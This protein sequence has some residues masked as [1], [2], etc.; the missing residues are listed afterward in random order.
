MMFSASGE[1]MTLSVNV[2][3][4][5]STPE[6]PN[7]SMAVVEV[8]GSATAPLPLLPFIMPKAVMAQM[9]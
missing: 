7:G 5:M 1:P 6:V 8:V 9:A 3:W 2:L 4:C